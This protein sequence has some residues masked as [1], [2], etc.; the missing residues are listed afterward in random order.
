MKDD[1]HQY[2]IRRFDPYYILTFPGFLGRDAYARHAATYTSGAE[3]RLV[4]GEDVA[5]Y[6]A[7][8]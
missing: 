4:A 1:R 6:T 5:I 8:N 3:R 2:N 7:V